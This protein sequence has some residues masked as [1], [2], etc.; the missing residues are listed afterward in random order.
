MNEKSMA[1]SFVK[2]ALQQICNNLDEISVESMDDDRG[3]LISISVATEDMGKVIGKSGQ[4]IS[5]LR[6]LISVISARE[7]KRYFLKVIDN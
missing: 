3:T 1:V 7:E 4:T 5:A 6:T 2:Y